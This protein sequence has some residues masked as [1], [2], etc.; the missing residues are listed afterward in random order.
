MRP[1]PPAR[2]ANREGDGDDGRGY[3]MAA[4]GAECGRRTRK[5]LP[6]AFRHA[7]RANFPPHTNVAGASA[8]PDVGPG[9]G[10][11]AR[12]PL[13]AGYYGHRGAWL[14][15]GRNV[16]L[17]PP[18]RLILTFLHTHFAGGPFSAA[19]AAKSVP[20]IPAMGPFPATSLT[21]GLP[22]SLSG[23]QARLR[24]LEDRGL[25]A[26]RPEGG[27]E[28]TSDAGAALGVV[29]AAQPVTEGSAAVA[30]PV[31]RVFE[32]IRRKIEAAGGGPALISQTRMAAEMGL[33]GSAVFSR[34]VDRLVEE[35]RLVR[36]DTTRHGT[37]LALPDA[38]AG[39]RPRL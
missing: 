21:P 29:A 2:S 8:R 31:E 32:A 28:L 3:G 11:W 24:R 13:T 25:V 27:W 15:R 14:A 17:R 19:E 10:R 38:P 16:E 22:C 39:V 30:R 5:P 1:L 26:R 36:L 9:F 23:W 6:R 12:K 4:R 18:D 37:K 34:Y 7:A 20:S 33:S 35:G